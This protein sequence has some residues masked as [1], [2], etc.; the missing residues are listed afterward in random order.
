[1][2]RLPSRLKLPLAVAVGGLLVIGVVW[3]GAQTQV[4]F[5]LWQNVA[6]RPLTTGEGRRLARCDRRPG[7][8]T[9]VKVLHNDRPVP[10]GEGWAIDRMADRIGRSDD[11]RRWVRQYV[12][13]PDTPPA[14]RLRAALL[15]NV[16][17]EATPEEPAWLTR[18]DAN[19][20]PE[21]GPEQARAEAWPWAIHLGPRAFAHGTMTGMTIAGFSAEEA[22]GAYEALWTL[23]EPALDADLVRWAAAGLNVAPTVSEDR[24]YRRLQGRPGTATPRGWSRLVLGRA[25]TCT[26]REDEPS[27]DC[28]E[29]WRD[30]LVLDAE[31]GS[32]SPMD[33]S[34]SDPFEYPPL[35]PALPALLP[36]L[37][38]MGHRTRAVEWWL[39]VAEEWI[40]TAPDPDRRLASLARGPAS[41]RTKAHPVATIYDRTSTPFMTA[42]VMMALGERTE[43]PVGVRVDDDG[44]IWLDVG[45]ELAALPRCG[46]LA[47]APPASPPWSADA[48]QAGAL[49]EAAA[50]ASDPLVQ[51]RL[52]A[53]S[54]ALE[55]TLSPA[56]ELPS[57]SGDDRRA[58][59][60]AGRRVL[61][62]DASSATRIEARPSAV[63]IGAQIGQPCE[64]ADPTAPSEPSPA[65]PGAE[66]TG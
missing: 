12:E 34:G 5:A 47:P 46:T 8:W 52:R 18:P 57:G 41:A 58:G 64:P 10:C 20:T 14:R 22:I 54:H 28:L 33:E 65:G 37:E 66:G 4:R 29:L 23:D 6:E 61:A 59:F 32:F 40:R 45:A 39:A 30:L 60:T 27:D 31:S 36:V 50:A 49:L 3:F 25:I 11:R 15:L 51:T 35:P 9:W 42:A 44:T 43:R 38:P 17:G 56:P 62:N 7:W 55:P 53:A 21:H 63:E 24:W 26:D 16:I 2:V 1:V 48:V 19:L 13:S